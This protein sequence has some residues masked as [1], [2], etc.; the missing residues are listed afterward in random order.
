[1]LAQGVAEM[2]LLP[3]GTYVVRAKVTSGSEPV[4][5]VRR[6]FT[7]MGAPRVAVDVKVPSAPLAGG[8][9]VAR[10][11]ARLLV[12]APPFALDQVLSPPILGAFLDRVAARSDAAAPAVRELLEHARTKGLGGLVISDA[13][14]SAAPVVA[15]L[16]GLT[17][18]ADKKL[19]P[20]AA[21]FRD[22]MRGSE[23]FYPAMVYLG[24]CYAAGGRDK[25]AAGAWRTALI[26]EGDTPAL[27]VM[28]A[29][30]FL[31]QGRGDLAVEW[32]EARIS[33]PD[34]LAHD[35][36]QLALALARLVG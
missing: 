4:G 33:R 2:R 16:R 35:P 21:A 7:V 18:L 28:L 30:A 15:F 11:A 14:A 9:T 8:T 25:E 19:E 32:V 6:A 20:A 24:A 29:D 13:Q 36:A 1:M 26:R 3:A 12:A 34:G 31:R 17:L 23:D 10:P 5:D 27:H 22:A